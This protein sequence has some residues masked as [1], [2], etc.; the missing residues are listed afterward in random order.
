MIVAFLCKLLSWKSQLEQDN[1]T[2][3]PV[4]QSISA[5]V[6]GAFSC[7]RLAAKIS[8]LINEFDRRFSDFRTQQSVFAIFA[9]PLTANVDSAPHH[10]QMEL[11]ELQSVSG[12]RAKFQDAPIKDFYH[13]LPPSLM[14]QL[15]LHDA[16][17][18]SMLGAPICVNRCFQL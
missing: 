6:P 12:L 11:I 4:C 17:V 5:S 9:N 1:L 13:L 18:L 3:F 7:T 2:H 14:P 10:L 16:C 15:R 8:R